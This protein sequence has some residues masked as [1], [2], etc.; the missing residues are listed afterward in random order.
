MY[1]KQHYMDSHDV[2]AQGA[3]HMI[4][5]ICE[6][7]RVSDRSLSEF[8]RTCVLLPMLW[9]NQGYR[10]L[11]FRLQNFRCYF[12]GYVHNL[13]LHYFYPGIHQEVQA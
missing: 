5:M 4:S 10:L 6:R 9:P 2:K 13:R 7:L 1:S 3:A 12:I 11:T 8:D